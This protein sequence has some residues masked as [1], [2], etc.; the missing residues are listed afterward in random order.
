[1]DTTDFAG[2]S[3]THFENG[4]IYRRVGADPHVVLG[5]IRGTWASMGWETSSLGFPTSDEHDVP[6]GRASDVERGRLRWNASTG[7]VRVG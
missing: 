7:R 5:A 1:M 3:V 6:G 2:G 4:S